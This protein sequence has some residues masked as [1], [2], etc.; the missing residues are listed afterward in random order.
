MGELMRALGKQFTA[1]QVYDFYRALRIVAL[2]RNKG[3][4][5]AGFGVAAVGVAASGLHAAHLLAELNRAQLVQEYAEAVG[6]KIQD[7]T[8]FYDEAVKCVYATVL[9]YMSP[10]CVVKVHEAMFPD[11]GRRPRALSARP[12]SA[13]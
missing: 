8:D 12:T 6:E 13:R 1:K 4:K 7:T 9:K 5:P 2:K 10:P 11:V 3:P